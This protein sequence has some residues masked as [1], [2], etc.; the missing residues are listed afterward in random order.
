M[1]SFVSSFS[2][3]RYKYYE[4]SWTIAYIYVAHILNFNKNNKQIIFDL[5]HSRGL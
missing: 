1:G 4:K 3:R 5:L 2:L